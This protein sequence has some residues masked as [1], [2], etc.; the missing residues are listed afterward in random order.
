MSSKFISQIKEFGINP[1]KIH[2]NLSV[3]K[4]LE[5]ATQKNE[6]MIT[7]T[8]SLSVK[9][10][11]YTGRSPDDRFIVFDDLTHDKVHWAK[12]NKQIPTETFE[13]LS[14]K[15]KKFVDGKELYIFDGFVGADPENRLP[16]RVINDHA[17]QSL[18]VHQLLIR[19]SATELESHEPEFTIICINDFEAIPEV[20]GTSSNAFILIN[21]SKKLVLIGTTNYAGEIK[22]AIFSVMNFILPSKGVF[23]MHCSANIGKDGDTSL[24]FGLSGTGKTSL[25]AD[26]QRMLIGDDEHG[27]SDKGIFNFE[28]GCYAKCIN[29]KEK[30]E[31]QIWNAV[32]NGAVLEN[33]V[34]NKESLKP[35]FDDGSLTE[36][37]RAAYPLD[38][39]PGAVIPS[40]G[41]NPK[42][43]IFLTADAMGVLPPLAKLSKNAAMF[44]FM[45]GYTSKLAGTEIGVKEPKAVFSK[46]FGAPFMPRP[47]SVYAEMLGEK[48]SKHNTSVYLINTGWSGGPYGVGERIKIE[49]SRAMVTAALT[50]SLDIVKFSHNDIFNLDVPTECPNVPSEVLEPRNMWID[51]DAYD[52]SA[53]KLAQMFVDNF[54]K[55]ENI[56]NEIR[57]AGPKI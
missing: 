50:G 14:Q 29:L 46:C 38:Y 21:L 6:G 11:K 40:V 37:T 26:P 39:I 45:S 1:S 12:V 35:D 8:G 49:Y 33:V 36:N 16:I 42:V 44:H 17:W 28:G 56:S 47:A 53:K 2:R 41:G 48:I 15:M 7:S 9:T 22:K 57:L 51:K 31:P 55:F 4:L 10:G 52:L 20:D 54:K 27:W 34:I 32:K 43:I 24:F 30:H 5:A 25:S 18:F 13:K 19:P 3:E 23:P